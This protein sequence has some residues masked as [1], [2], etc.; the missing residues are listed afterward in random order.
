MTDK[1]ICAERYCSQDVFDE[2][3][4]GGHAEAEPGFEGRRAFTF[5][6][7]RAAFTRWVV[8]GLDDPRLNHVVPLGE[9]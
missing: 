9:R 3:M 8:V 6:P 2:L 1:E 5:N 4:A 7:V